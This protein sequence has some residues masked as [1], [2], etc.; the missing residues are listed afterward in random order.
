[1]CLGISVW[2]NIVEGK[3]EYLLQMQIHF[4]IPTQQ[5][6]PP[7]PAVETQNVMQKNKYW[8]R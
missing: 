7:P 8:F 1:M 3:L 4:G 2:S 6:P 5:Y